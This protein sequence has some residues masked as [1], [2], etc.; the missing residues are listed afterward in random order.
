MTKITITE[1]L[2][3]G[4]T[5]EKRI[6]KKRQFVRDYLF[7]QEQL[8]DPLDGGS[9]IAISRELQSIWQQTSR[10]GLPNVGELLHGRKSLATRPHTHR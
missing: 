5:I 6:A 2:A 4:T 7:R 10:K 1:A 8:R 9:N 3:E